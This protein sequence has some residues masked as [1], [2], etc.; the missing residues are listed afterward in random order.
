M[1]N[2]VD[3]R[4]GT[5]EEGEQIVRSLVSDLEDAF[6]GYLRGDI[7]FDELT[8]DVF[9]T[10]QAVHAVARGNFSIEYVEGEDEDVEEQEE[11][12]QEP[13]R[14]EPDRRQR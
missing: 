8:F 1:A 11:L 6:L 14:E 7:G 2:D 4:E 10:L 5:R 12:A 9:D 3:D 13:S